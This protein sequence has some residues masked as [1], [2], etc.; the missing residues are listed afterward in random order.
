M[1]KCNKIDMEVTLKGLSPAQVK[2]L[3][4]LHDS[5]ENGKLFLIEQAGYTYEHETY[6]VKF[7]TD[8]LSM[9]GTLESGRLL[10]QIWDALSLY[11]PT[12]VNLGENKRP[13]ECQIMLTFGSIVSVEWPSEFKEVS[14]TR[15]WKGWLGRLAI[16]FM[17]IPSTGITVGRYIGETDD[18]DYLCYC[19]MAGCIEHPPRD[20]REGK[21][22]NHWSD[23]R[24]SYPNT[25]KCPHHVSA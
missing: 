10:A 23:E 24:G 14:E 11:P 3:H 15:M 6:Q 2:A 4:D 5:D 22:A 17:S 13:E 8:P 7:S 9:E 20:T 18:H 1:K 16:K 12:R 21:E 25:E 19:P